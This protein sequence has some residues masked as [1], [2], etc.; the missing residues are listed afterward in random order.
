MPV[1]TRHMQFYLFAT[2]PPPVFSKNDRWECSFWCI[3]CMLLWNYIFAAGCA[4]RKIGK[5]KWVSTMPCKVAR[6]TGAGG[7]VGE[8]VVGL[9]KGPGPVPTLQP[10]MHPTWR[11]LPTPACHHSGSGD[12]EMESAPLL[13]GTLTDIVSHCSTVFSLMGF[14][15]CCNI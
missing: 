10:G 8:W 2:L 15:Y 3:D 1:Q 9:P 12:F 5:T 11:T 6:E 4:G 13:L 7:R 14:S